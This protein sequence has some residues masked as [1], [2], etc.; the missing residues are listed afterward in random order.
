MEVRAK[1]APMKGPQ[2]TVRLRTKK[3][4]D[5]VKRGARLCNMSVNTF[6]AEAMA[7]A[8]QSAIRVFGEGGL[9]SAIKAVPSTQSEASQ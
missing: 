7:N 3:E 1:K 8:A 4:L 5:L 9:A 2:V 6:A